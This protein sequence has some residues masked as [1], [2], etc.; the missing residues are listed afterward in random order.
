MVIKVNG[1]NI[2]TPDVKFGD[3]KKLLNDHESS[4]KDDSDDS[5]CS[6]IEIEF[7]L[8]EPFLIDLD[9]KEFP[10][11]VNEFVV[12]SDALLQ[13]RFPITL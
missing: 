9:F 7:D 12:V 8:G 5:N 4:E 13:I 11:D 10:D 3:I 1:N 2:M 6:T